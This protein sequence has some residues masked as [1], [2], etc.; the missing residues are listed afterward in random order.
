VSDDVSNGPVVQLGEALQK[1]LRLSLQTQTDLKNWDEQAAMFSRL[2]RALPP[3]IYDRLPHEIEHFLNDT[4]IR[5]KDRSYAE[6]QE[7]E[8]RNLVAFLIHGELPPRPGDP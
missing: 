2:L 8:M 5:L 6:G 1:L 3:D 4:N 7:E